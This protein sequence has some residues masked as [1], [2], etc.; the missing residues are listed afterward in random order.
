[1]CSLVIVA[2]RAHF[3]RQFHVTPVIAWRPSVGKTKNGSTLRSSWWASSAQQVTLLSTTTVAAVCHNIAALEILLCTAGRISRIFHVSSSF[4]AASE[5]SNCRRG[6]RSWKDGPRRTY[7]SSSSAFWKKVNLY[8]S[9][10]YPQSYPFF[11][12]TAA[13]LSPWHAG[14]FF[15]CTKVRGPWERCLKTR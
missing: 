4:A 5:L 11:C 8:D 6:R 15:E 2:K 3:L 13:R 7:D 14:H 1:M 9:I 12:L 10:L